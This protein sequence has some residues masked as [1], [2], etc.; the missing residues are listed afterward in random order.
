[1]QPLQLRD[2][3]I[4]TI[5]ISLGMLLIQLPTQAQ[6]TFAPTNV[7]QS[8]SVINGI[9][10][11]VNPNN[12]QFQTIPLNPAASSG[13]GVFSGLP[14]NSAISPGGWGNPNIGGLS[15]P[16]DGLFNS[17]NSAV[18][19]LFG[20]NGL[21]GILG[22]N[23]SLGGLLGGN[24]NALGGLLGGNNA[25]A[26]GNELIAVIQGYINQIGQLVQNPLGF[27]NI[28]NEKLP[29]GDSLAHIEQAIQAN[30]GGM[31]LPDLAKTK[32]DAMKSQQRMSTG[33]QTIDI[34]HLS[35]GQVL[36]RTT[37]SHTQTILGKAG[38]DLQI[39]GMQAV[40]KSIGTANQAVQGSSQTASQV[41]QFAQQS[42][43]V[44]QSTAQVAKTSSQTAQQ[45]T[46]SAGKIQKAIS[47]QDAIKGLGEQNAQISNILAGLSNQMGG[48]SNQLSTVA[49]ELSGLSN[50]TAQAAQQIGQVAAI[51]GDQ[52]VSLRNL[53]VTGAITNANLNEMN[54]IQHGQQRRESLER[55][56][57]ALL[58]AAGFFRLSK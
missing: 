54:Q 1:M 29:L 6:L 30:K 10:G 4:N 8:P 49:S 33:Y 42:G 22:G 50:Q 47:T 23:S 38:Q 9:T 27:L 36:N 26:S 52:A 25:S 34:F 57:Y 40:Q 58:P 43:S 35:L 7:I 16:L 41:G 53:Q 37:Q 51:S 11:A 56:S 46:A 2:I 20:N 28:L 45:T 31:G 48:S 24:S 55:Q 15:N 14:T 39:Q 19:G 12:I 32:A 13:L 44:A 21:G 5:G 18:G 3:S 17:A